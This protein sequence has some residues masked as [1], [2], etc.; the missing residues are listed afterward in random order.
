MSGADMGVYDF[1]DSPEEGNYGK[2]TGGKKVTKRQQV[3]SG[4]ALFQ[5]E[6]LPKFKIMYSILPLNQIKG[7]V[8]DKWIRMMKR[9]QVGNGT[10]P[11]RNPRVVNRSGQKGK[12]GKLIQMHPKKVSFAEPLEHDDYHE[13][14]LTPPQ[15]YKNLLSGDNGAK[16]GQNKCQLKLFVPH[17]TRKRLFQD[18]T[19]SGIKQKRKAPVIKASSGGMKTTTDERIIDDNHF[20]QVNIPRHRSLFQMFNDSD[21][22]EDDHDAHVEYQESC[23]I[24][25]TPVAATGPRTSTPKPMVDPVTHDDSDA[26]TQIYFEKTNGQ[27]IRD[28]NDESDA[29]DSQATYIIERRH[30]VIF[31]DDKSTQDTIIDYDGETEV[32]DNPGDDDQ[33]DKS[34]GGG[35]KDFLNKKSTG[36]NR[37][38]NVRK[39]P[40]LEKTNFIQ[41]DHHH[42]EDR[43]IKHRHEDDMDGLEMSRCSTNSDVMSFRKQETTPKLQTSVRQQKVH[44]YSVLI[45]PILMLN[46]HPMDNTIDASVE[47]SQDAMKSGDNN[48]PRHE[49]KKDKKENKKCSGLK[50]LIQMSA[51]SA[52]RKSS[53][54]DSGIHRDIENMTLETPK[55]SGMSET[56]LNTIGGKDQL[57]VVD[58][59]TTFGSV[60]QT[61][62]KESGMTRSVF[63]PQA[64]TYGKNI[65]ASYSIRSPSVMRQVADDDNHGSITGI[66]TPLTS[67]SKRTPQVISKTVPSRRGLFA[68]KRGAG[69]VSS[70]FFDSVEY[71]DPGL[72]E[73]PTQKE[74]FKN[75]LSAE[76]EEVIQNSMRKPLAQSTPVGNKKGKS[77][78]EEG[79]DGDHEDD[80]DYDETHSSLSRKM[81]QSNRPLDFSQFMLTHPGDK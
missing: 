25:E 59:N 42:L 31:G 27:N 79:D 43:E 5:K 24:H 30:P 58:N 39:S 8:K 52:P 45:K 54:V 74:L 15:V 77:Y 1:P 23:V 55:T 36:K 47:L 71:T 34:C 20:H 50:Y 81:F 57:A 68:E 26:H 13:E 60:R 73:Q 9:G 49:V 70:G 33:M 61:I 65:H 2:K 3:M 69:D 62:V 78:R 63:G 22:D 64:K 44:K 51:A 12:R 67:Q 72:Y 80:D 53:I 7:M 76:S 6:W 41:K 21:D 48:T 18:N 32:E 40:R 17:Q 10:P 16:S 37:G 66:N 35:I 28:N 14:L 19:P 11:V 38:R 56:L 29:D 4:Y 75:N 46:R